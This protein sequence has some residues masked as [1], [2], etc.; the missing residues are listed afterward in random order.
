MNSYEVEQ[1]NEQAIKDM[2][3]WAEDDVDSKVLCAAMALCAKV[4]ELRQR[5]EKLEG[6]PNDQHDAGGGSGASDD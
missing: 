1:M 2:L 3:G 5:V 6:S 4:A